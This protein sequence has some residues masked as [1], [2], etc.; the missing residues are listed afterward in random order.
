MYTTAQKKSMQLQASVIRTM[1]LVSA[2]FAITWTPL[3]VYYLLIMIN[4]DLSLLDSWYYALMSIA[5][6]YIC[7]NPFTPCYDTCGHA[8]PLC[9]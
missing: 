8:H 7:T 6:L 2:F 5:F 9:G 3:D 4:S 1:V